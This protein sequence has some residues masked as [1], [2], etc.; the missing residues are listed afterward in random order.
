MNRFI[1]T[2][3]GG[4][5]N[6]N[7]VTLIRPQH[8]GCYTLVVTNEDGDA[9]EVLVQTEQLDSALGCS[10]FVPAPR[11]WELVIHDDK[12]VCVHSE[13]IIAWRAPGMDPVTLNQTYRRTSTLYK[14]VAPSGEVF[15]DPDKSARWRNWDAFKASIAA[16]EGGAQ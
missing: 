16:N 4:W 15:G 6:L 1:R 13:P 7:R 9:E 8:G 2:D 12:G 3:D 5:V 10:E 11:G 14:I